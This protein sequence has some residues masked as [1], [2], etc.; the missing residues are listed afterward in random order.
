MS[1]EPLTVIALVLC[2]FGLGVVVGAQVERYL[3]GRA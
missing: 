2:F 1:V 3:S